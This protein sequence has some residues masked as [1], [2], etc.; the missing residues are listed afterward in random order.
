MAMKPLL[1]L[2]ETVPVDNQFELLSV[3][4]NG[5]SIKQ[6]FRD[7]NNP[8]I[9]YLCFNAVVMAISAQTAILEPYMLEENRFNGAARAVSANR[10]EEVKK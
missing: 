2:G 3:A 5:K 7:N 1:R 4:Q 10:P 9:T 8:P 6:L